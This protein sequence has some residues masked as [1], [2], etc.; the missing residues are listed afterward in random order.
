MAKLPFIE[1]NVSAQAARLGGA[2]LGST[3]VSGAISKGV[4]EA[5]NLGEFILKKRDADR[6]MEEQA[7][8][9]RF[10]T[11]DAELLSQMVNE[12]TTSDDINS[13]EGRYSQS[14]EDRYKKHALEDLGL[15]EGS[16]RYERMREQYQRKQGISIQKAMLGG[17]TQK[18]A[19]IWLENAESV[20]AEREKAVIKNPAM[21]ESILEEGSVFSDGAIPPG[22]NQQALKEARE[23]ESSRLAF[24]AGAELIE[25][26]TSADD[27]ADLKDQMM[28]EKGIFFPNLLPAHLDK[29]DN[30]LNTKLNGMKAKADKELTAYINAVSAGVGQL[31]ASME[32]RAA[33]AD[34]SEQLELA[35]E[36]WQALKQVAKGGPKEWAAA[37]E[38]SDADLAD[39]AP[40]AAATAQRANTV[41]RSS[42]A[43]LQKQLADDPYTYSI[44]HNDAI[45]EK[46]ARV[47]ELIKS[48]EDGAGAEAI[49]LTQ[50]LVSEIDAHQ[51]QLGVPSYDRKITGKNDPVGYIMADAIRGGDKDTI[52]GT[53]AFA[54]EAYGAYFDRW[55]SEVGDN[56][57]PGIMPVIMA[58]TESGQVIA[59]QYANV[60]DN[61]LEDMVFN[62]TGMSGTDLKTDMNAAMQEISANIQ[63]THRPEIGG[64]ERALRNINMI[65]RFA[66]VRLA[67]GIESTAADA[68]EGAYQELYGSV[69]HVAVGKSAVRV[70]T[71]EGAVSPDVIQDGLAVIQNDPSILPI[72]DFDT[73]EDLAGMS[74]EKQRARRDQIIRENIVM[75]NTPDGSGYEFYVQGDNGALKPL[76]NRDT[77]ERLIMSPED[78]S[79]TLDAVRANRMISPEKLRRSDLRQL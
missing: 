61:E 44:Q 39:V 23:K 71:V 73:G 55:M 68:V 59:A 34:K 16:D 12:A 42:I 50:E 7:S 33:A 24:T 41:L 30:A 13:L 26:A 17:I 28:D 56:L 35:E 6:Q 29:L 4:S 57:P 18:N 5:R 67:H 31:D 52:L 69:E 53:V 66:K 47:A 38:K 78:I 75:H 76:R 11:Q 36:N 14:F 3:A 48:G 20:A 1:E 51:A 64:P 72:A 70:S 27:L 8:N 37:L 65:K 25:R 45:G 40:L 15:E 21:L 46:S 9:A 58:E 79:E 63:A 32:A 62:A 54:R 22:V 10:F 49:Q 43:R 19:A 74:A 77:G 2:N 60:K